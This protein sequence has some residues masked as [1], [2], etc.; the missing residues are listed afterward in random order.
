MRIIKLTILLI[1]IGM[2]AKSQFFVEFSTGYSFSTKP[3]VI[4]NIL[5]IE[6]RISEFKEEYKFGK[7]LDYGIS[8]GYTVNEHLDFSLFMHS[9]T[10]SSSDFNLDLTQYYSEYGSNFYFS[11]NS[12]S[13]EL[14]MKTIQV[15][16]LLVLRKS[17]NKIS[18]YLKVGPN[19]LKL[20]SEFVNE[21]IELDDSDTQVAV[22]ET[23]EYKGKV[24][25]GLIVAVGLSMKLGDSFFWYAEVISCN[26]NYDFTD[27]TISEFS[28]DNIDRKDEL[29]QT[30]FEYSNNEFLVDYSNIGFNIGI[31]YTL[32]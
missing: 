8:F 20:Q 15:A 18:P 11:G 1:I 12:G 30:S 2:Q 31:R 6:D 17:Y 10:L 32:Q 13:T 26:S 9:K 21:R 28:V 5:K 7:G 22:N 24:D 27:L 16:P 23:S 29:E 4:R 3:Y 14:T 19:F 25:I